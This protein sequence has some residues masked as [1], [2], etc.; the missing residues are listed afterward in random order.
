MVKL[1]DA[2]RAET[3]VAA[4]AQ[5]GIAITPAAAFT[6]GSGHAPNAVRLALGSPALN[7]LTPAL[8]TLADL[9]REKP[10]VWNTE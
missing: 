8:Q 3:Y 1:P 7:V 10:S 4:A 6:V 5:R 2:W 9:A